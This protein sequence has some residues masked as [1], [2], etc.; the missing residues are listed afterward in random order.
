MAATYSEI[1][2]WIAATG[3]LPRGGFHPGPDDAVPPM[4]DGRT[5]RTLILIGNAGPDLWQRLAPFLVRHPDLPNPLN[6]WVEQTVGLLA[7][8]FGARAVYTHEGPPFRPF[9]RWAQRAEPVTPSPIGLL[10]HPVYGLWHAYRAALLFADEI[11]LPPF[12]PAP[13]PCDSCA[14]KPCLAAGPVDSRPR[15][16]FD[17]AR[18]ACPIGMD[19]V[20]GDA[21]SAFHQAA[22]LG[23]RS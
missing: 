4:A 2:E 14:A 18:R 7:P 11:A 10:I 21:Q 6:S 20:Y 8:V 22:F 17:T 23:R 15:A 5:T 19:Y 9:L 13:S 1:T 12:V 3:L 16:G